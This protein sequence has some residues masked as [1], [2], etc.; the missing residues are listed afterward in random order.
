[1]PIFLSLTLRG[2]RLRPTGPSFQEFNVTTFVFILR[3]SAIRVQMRIP[4]VDFSPFTIVPL[5]RHG[6]SRQK[7]SW[8][9]V[10]SSW[11]GMVFASRATDSLRTRCESSMLS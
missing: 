8:I 3:Q 5:E 9:R 1:M 6:S 7:R 11:F 4:I 2:G 10:S